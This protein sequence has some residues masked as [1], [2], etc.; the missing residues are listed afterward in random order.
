M[1][2]NTNI[3][4]TTSKYDRIKNKLL[5]A[6]N[7]IA[8]KHKTIKHKVKNLVHTFDN[9]TTSNENLHIKMST[10][11]LNKLEESDLDHAS[12]SEICASVCTDLN[13]STTMNACTAKSV[14]RKL[15]VSSSRKDEKK[16]EP[17]L[18]FKIPTKSCSDPTLMTKIVH[19]DKKNLLAD[20]KTSHDLLDKQDRRQ[21]KKLEHR[22][23]ECICRSLT[24]VT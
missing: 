6:K 4:F 22:Y 23:Y 14:A 24:A 18:K 8:S 11:K 13:K 7:K 17:R 10:K 20:T 5:L 9:N 1:L 16:V 21:L 15:V 2:Q 3:L 12:E 19:V